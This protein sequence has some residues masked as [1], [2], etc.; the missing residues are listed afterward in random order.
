MCEVGGECC[1]NDRAVPALP[2]DDVAGFTTDGAHD[3]G[4]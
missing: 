1:P 3:V 4:P 2:A